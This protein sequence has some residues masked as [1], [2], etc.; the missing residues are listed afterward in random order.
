MKFFIYMYIYFRYREGLSKP[1]PEEY[2]CIRAF[3]L[4]EVAKWFAEQNID[5]NSVIKVMRLSDKK[6]PYLIHNESSEKSS[7]HLKR[8]V[9]LSSGGI[10][11][12]ALILHYCIWYMKCKL[13][14]FHQIREGSEDAVGGLMFEP[15]QHTSPPVDEVRALEQLSLQPKPEVSMNTT[16]GEPTCI[17]CDQSWKAFV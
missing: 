9:L 5:G 11:V 2:N 8:S 16:P 13:K 14:F 17:L 6:V 3:R 12:H 7:F 15:M 10:L 4:T 1:S